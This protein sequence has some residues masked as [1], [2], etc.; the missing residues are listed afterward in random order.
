MTAHSLF[1]P[2]RAAV[3]NMDMQAGIV[4]A[5]A[6][7]QEGFPDRAASVLARARELGML[8]IHIKVGF[9]KGLP[10]VSSRNPLFGAIKTSE[11][12]QRLFEG[13]LGAI[14]PSLG[15]APDD[16]VITKHRVSA[17]TG[18]DLDMILRATE[19]DTLVLFGIATSGVVLSTLVE[20]ADRDYRL[21]VIKDCC[22]DLDADLHRTLI[23]NF[24]PKRGKVISTSEFLAAEKLGE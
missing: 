19:I 11:K 17:F 7:D 3:L 18:T 15:P 12:H 13:D 8:V 9:R 16:I 5:Y 20:A 22:V 6:K 2:S 23:E 14:H 1:D 4:S 24:F 21:I 10:E